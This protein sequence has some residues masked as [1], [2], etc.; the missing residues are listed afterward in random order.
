MSS[1]STSRASAAPPRGRRRQAIDLLVRT[2][3][4]PDVA[5]ARMP[6][7]DETRQH[8]VQLALCRRPH[9][10]DAALGALQQVVARPVLLGEQSEDH[11]FGRRQLRR[12][13]SRNSPHRTIQTNTE[14]ERRSASKRARVTSPRSSPSACSGSGESQRTSIR[15]RSCPRNALRGGLPVASANIDQHLQLDF[16]S[17]ERLRP[18]SDR[19]RAEPRSRHR[20][21]DGSPMNGRRRIPGSCASWPESLGPTTRRCRSPRTSTIRRSAPSPS[22]RCA[23]PSRIRRA[24]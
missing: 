7:C 20:L 9:V 13:L 5:P 10:R 18:R 4:L 22:T 21:A 14:T 23:T 6:G 2:P 1:A 8:G 24:G 15:S 12:S 16:G 19:L 3:P 11:A 17:Q